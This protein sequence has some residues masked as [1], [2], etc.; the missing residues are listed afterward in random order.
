MKRSNRRKA[1]TGWPRGVYSS[2][3]WGRRLLIGAAI[4]LL[5]ACRGV[6]SPVASIAPPPSL[7]S[8]ALESG[9]PTSTAPAS[10]S[11]T[12][13]D[14]A[15]QA[16]QQPPAEQIAL[17]QHTTPASSADSDPRAAI[18][19]TASVIP[20]TAV[21]Q[22][23]AS[24]APHT[25]VQVVPQYPQPSAAG[26]PQQPCAPYGCGPCAPAVEPWCPDGVP[27]GGWRPPGLTCPWP[28]DEY[29]CDGDDKIP[30]VRVREDWSLD[31][32]QLEDT[33]VHYDTLDGE[34]FVEPSNRVCIYA[35]RF[36]SVRKVYGVVQ[37]DHLDRI[38]R[39]DN[40]V[41]IEG[42]DD[43]QKPTTS[44]QP[45]QPV[46][47]H[48]TST[49]SGFRELIPP[50]GLENRQ[51]LVGIQGRVLPYED[52]TDL[53]RELLTNTEK[54][55]LADMIQAAVVWTD[56]LPL[57]VII[58][59]IATHEDI[60]ATAAESVHIYSLEG[61]PR[62][63]VCKLASSKEARPGETVE[64]TLQFENVGDQT[65]G[66][67][68]VVDN[69]TTRLEYVEDSQTCSLK[70][71]FSSEPNQG[72]SLALRWEIVEPMKVGEG[73]VIRFKCRVR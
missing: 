27:C 2:C 36:A 45:V 43:V 20:H 19:N 35:P 47:S 68:T 42:L 52:I 62:L 56:A 28:E 50:V 12:L 1:Q 46:L 25:M 59:N 67:V 63:R 11:H 61:K 51:R 72:D 16:P 37:Y 73:G 13:S 34:T 21:P 66:N 53:Q 69:L 32:L 5:S 71:N 70:A 49:A 15:R 58:D 22:I 9:E 39:V 4:L 23:P 3:S 55:R 33:I 14:H 57:Q 54:A 41:P 8:T 17:T 65:I 44:I 30:S 38:A 48:G 10:A 64:F 29:L 31:G 6:E 24:P 40:P 26:Y 60:A 7:P 18:P